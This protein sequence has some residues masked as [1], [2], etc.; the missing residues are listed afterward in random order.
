MAAK[1]RDFDPLRGMI[2]VR[3]AGMAAAGR[4]SGTSAS[5]EPSSESSAGWDGPHHEAKVGNR[6]TWAQSPERCR[7]SP[8]TR[9]RSS[10]SCE[11][12]S[13]ASPETLPGVPAVRQ[14]R[15]PKTTANPFGASKTTANPFGAY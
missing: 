10:R 2:K 1:V 7:R 3:E 14:A 8:R 15:L 12:T 13:K 5:D 6:S 4:A 11:P 9:L